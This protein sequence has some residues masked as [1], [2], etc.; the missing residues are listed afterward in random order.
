MK[1]ATST[2]SELQKMQAKFED[3]NEQINALVNKPWW[4]KA[5]EK[6][7]YKQHKPITNTVNELIKLKAIGSSLQADSFKEQ[8][9]EAPTDVMANIKKDFDDK[10]MPYHQ[11]NTLLNTF[12]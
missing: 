1:W 5:I 3:L 10:N 12:G 6:S 9:F 11:V 7:L 4:T 8:R 2:A